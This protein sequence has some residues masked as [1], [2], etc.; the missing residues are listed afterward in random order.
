M[1]EFTEQEVK[2]AIREF[3][4]AVGDVLNASY[5][6]YVLKMKR[7]VQLSKDNPVINSIVEP[8]Y[9]IDVDFN[10]IHKPDGGGWI[11]L[12]LPVN[13]DEQIAYVFKVFQLASEQEGYLDTLT[14]TIYKN[15]RIADNISLY[16]S[17]VVSSSLRELRYRLGDL[18]ED[19]KGREEIPVA[20]LQIINNGTLTAQHGS[21]IA[22]GKDIQQNINYSNIKEDIMSKVKESG[23]VPQDSLK[24]VEKLSSELEEELNQP[25]PN[26]SK[27]KKVA[28]KVLEIGE[29][30]LLRIF[31]TVVTDPRWG[32]AVSH[33]LLN[34]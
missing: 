30:G 17:D 3:D 33:A 8:I 11:E 34:M 25:E 15:K 7:I 18:M 2:R 28:Q 13:I 24:E 6:T 1:H 10:E 9:F 14:F 31:S 5:S 21:T 19:I 16:L 12:N 26:E 27:L 22:V 4:S 20:S 23:L 32:Q 29:N